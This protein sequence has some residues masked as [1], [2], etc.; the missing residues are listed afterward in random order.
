MKLKA[1]VT[2]LVFFWAT[3]AQAEMKIFPL[4]EEKTCDG[5][6][7]GCYSFDQM[8]DI[9]KLDLNLQLKLKSC[10]LWEQKYNS[11]DEAYLKLRKAFDLSQDVRLRLETRLDEK[12]AVILDLSKQVHK[13]ADRDIWGSALPWVVVVVVLA[14]AGGVVAGVYV[15]K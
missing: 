2:L 7:W 14:F 5:Q 4:W 9:L 6:T 3:L 10:E 8:K 12:S 13:Y 1:A 15:S 11:L